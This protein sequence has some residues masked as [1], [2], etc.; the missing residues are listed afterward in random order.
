MV[1]TFHKTC[2]YNTRTQIVYW[3]KV[4]FFGYSNFLT[5]EPHLT[6]K[7]DYNDIKYNAFPFTKSWHKHFF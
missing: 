1:T 3:Q 2:I 4:T 5:T 7:F 6:N